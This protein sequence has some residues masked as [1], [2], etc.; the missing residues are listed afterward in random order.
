[1][2]VIALIAQKGGTGK[3]MLACALA[4]AIAR[5][6]PSRLLDLDPQGTAM[7]WGVRRQANDFGPPDVDAVPQ[8]SI[9]AALHKAG[10]SGVEVCVID[11][12][13]HTETAV[14]DAAALADLILVPTRPVIPDFG[15]IAATIQV[16]R[17]N[18]IQA[19]VYAVINQAFPVGTR[20]D[21]F[22]AALGNYDIPACPHLVVQRVAHHDSSILGQTACEYQP[23][24]PAAGEM[25]QL[26]DWAEAQLF[27]NA[28]RH[29]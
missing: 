26:H 18:Q 21:E 22:F 25:Q 11:T 19:P 24:G 10:K 14:I 28:P 23:A 5:Q 7:Q 13:P 9:N 16:C 2:K 3:T 29:G 12:P 6:R 1:M 8:R 4:T 27:G 17:S 15:G 20:N